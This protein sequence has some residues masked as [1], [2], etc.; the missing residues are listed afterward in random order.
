MVLFKCGKCGRI[1]QAQDA[2]AGAEMQCASCGTAQPVPPASD[3]DCHLIYSETAPEPTFAVTDEQFAALIADKKLGADDL[4]YHEGGWKQLGSLY[5]LPL[6]ELPA[7]N[8]DQP[9]IAV[10]LRELKPLDGF[11]KLPR[12]GG[13]WFGWFSKKGAAAASS[14]PEEAVPLGRRILNW[15][16][17]ALALAVVCYGVYRAMLIYNYFNKKFASVAV[18]NQTAKPMYF[19]RDGNESEPRLVSPTSPGVF[20]DINV[21]WSWHTSLD[22]WPGDGKSLGMPAKPADHKTVKVPVAPMQD[23]VVNLEGAGKFHSLSKDAKQTLEATEPLP[24]EYKDML[25][26]QLNANQAPEAARE[27][28][29][30]VLAKVAEPQFVAVTGVF[31]HE[32]EF[33]FDLLNIGDGD[34]KPRPAPKADDKRPY[35]VPPTEVRLP[36]KG[37][38]LRMIKAKEDVEVPVSLPRTTLSPAGNQISGNFTLTIRRDLGKLTVALSGSNLRCDFAPKPT[39]SY[40]ATLD[41]KRN[42]WQYAWGWTSGQNQW[43]LDGQG[44]RQTK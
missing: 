2:D 38:A 36:M 31:F 33:R 37:G 23:T 11:P 43:R 18:Y 44:F 13:G 25:L 35:L 26:K 15:C 32:R 28:L 8:Q 19:T 34:R 10:A 5:E 12:K 21:P 22:Y 27:I 3:P 7:V 20:T 39:L 24:K 9:E 4:M 29:D 40:T 41:L 6:K 14:G 17:V 30:A 42:A 16:K 1:L